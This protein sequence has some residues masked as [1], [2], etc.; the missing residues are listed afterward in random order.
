VREP[1]PTRPRGLVGD[2]PREVARHAEHHRRS[3]DLVGRERPDGVNPRGQRAETS[4]RT[5]TAAPVSCGRQG[6][7]ALREPAQPPERSSLERV[8]PQRDE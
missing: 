2:V 3:V 4:W 8:R 1:C 5:A 7:R 6:W